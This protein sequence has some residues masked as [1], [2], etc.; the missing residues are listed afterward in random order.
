MHPPAKVAPM[1]AFKQSP[2]CPSPVAITENRPD[3]VA[4]ALRDLVKI[5]QAKSRETFVTLN[6]ISLDIR[7]EE[8]LTII[9]PSGCGKSTLL[10]LMAGLAQPTSGSISVRG[11]SG[12]GRPNLGYISQTDTLLPWRDVLGNV[13]IGLEMRGMERQERRQRARQLMA[14]VGLQGFEKSYPFELSGGM[15]KRVAV[16][17]TLAYD[18]DIIFMDE[19]FVGL[20]VQTRDM[21][22]EDILRLWQEHRKTIVLV[23]HDLAEAIALSDRVV[24]LTARP[25]MIKNVYDIPLPR[26]RSVVECK[27]T[28]EFVRLHQ[29]IWRDLSA[30]VIRSAEEGSHV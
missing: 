9:G 24:L 23:T 15:R 19:P 16:I 22:E 14:Q 29:R 20:D 11:T 6:G 4:V 30:E 27:F 8:F 13:E 1:N 5:H 26:P 17:R 3:D 2:A 10:Q 12:D 21:L 18:P 7:N 25:A 28:E